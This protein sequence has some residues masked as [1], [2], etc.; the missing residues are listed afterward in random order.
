MIPSKNFGQ[1]RTSSYNQ[2]KE[3]LL[4][5]LSGDRS[6]EKGGYVKDSILMEWKQGKGDL[7]MGLRDTQLQCGQYTESSLYILWFPCNVILQHFFLVLYQTLEHTQR[8][9]KPNQKV[10]S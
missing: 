2:T 3:L 6:T 4:S 9:Q 1:T 5:Y 7:R 8:H 10:N